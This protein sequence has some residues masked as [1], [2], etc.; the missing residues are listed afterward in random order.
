MNERIELELPQRFC[1]SDENGNEFRII[2]AYLYGTNI[3]MHFN[4][5]GDWKL[6]LRI[7][8]TSYGYAI[9]PDCQT[10]V[11]YDLLARCS[12]ALGH[13]VEHLTWIGMDEE[14]NATFEVV[15]A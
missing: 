1:I 15:F 4:P 14:G 8:A 12:E 3:D 9:S 13:N 11:E 5:V 7:Y 6:S 10:A 2:R